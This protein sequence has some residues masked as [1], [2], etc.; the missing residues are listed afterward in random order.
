[1]KSLRS[2]FLL[3]VLLPVILIFGTI[4]AYSIARF[5]QA[6]TASAVA[7]TNNFTELYASEI[8]Y[9]L[10][11]TFAIG[12]I[13]ADMVAG[14][15]ETGE[16]VKSG[17]RN[18]LIN[19]LK[20]L[21]LLDE[22]IYGVW[23]GMEPD[24]YDGMDRFLAGTANHDAT[25][26]FIPYAYRDGQS[27]G[28]AYLEDYNVPGA[29]DYY[30]LAFRSGKPQIVEP[31]DYIIDGLSVKM[32][33]L[34]IPIRLNGKVIGVAG[35]DM[36]TDSLVTIASAL[37]VYDN[38][39]GRLLTN[40]GLVVYHPDQARIGKVENEFSSAEGKQV[41]RDAQKGIT[42]TSWGLSNHLKAESYRT[43]V[44]IKVADIETQWIL[45]SVV[46]KKEM[47]AEVMAILWQITIVMGV[48]FIALAAIILT[49]SGTIVNPIRVLTTFIERIA[50]LDLRPEHKESILPF[51]KKKDE[52]G[53]IA[54][55]L[56][57]M[58]TAL[59]E[60]TTQLQG[61]SSRV[62][63]DS[64]EIAASVGEN[65]AAIQ[66]VTSSMGE[67]GASVSQT[68]DHSLQM[69]ADAKAVEGLASDGNT[70]MRQTLQAMEQIVKLSRES[71]QAL[72]ALSSHVATM[73]GV[74]KIIADVADQTNLLA[75]NAAIEAAR[76][77]E[78]GRG[79]AVVADEV[80]GLAEQT[81]RSVAEINH[82]VAELV[83]NAATS[84]KLMDGTE[85]QI[86][87]GSGLLTQTEVAFGQINE[88]I[89]AVARAIQEF[90]IV[91]GDMSDMGTSVAAAAEEQAASMGEIAR[92]AESL[93]DLGNDLQ[94]IAKRFVI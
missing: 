7:L 72:S 59:F 78:H 22:H 17:S 62:A 26:R 39:Y 49:V 2:R 15:I 20:R 88:R 63:V 60:V 84:T 10:E 73:E 25:G 91:L 74:L 41:L 44:P 21:V 38:G 13:V 93:S 66:E 35:V 3:L 89:N 83:N 82:M 36:T 53:Q 47:L 55:A 45:G 19:T 52:V 79:F 33:T 77:G 31:F 23:L 54:N 94:D 16:A 71:R 64:Q 9:K 46:V 51:L 12:R 1:M 76:A 65:S 70:Q 8:E 56:D 14:Q 75:L 6:Q 30:Q 85:G 4:G 69:G 92:S 40:T 80:R 58:Q 90:T 27:V 86:Q 42:A 67:L 48:A 37:K 87:V 32:I 5:Y 24:A 68:R 11:S 57:G 34:S 18:S 61:I 29:G 50:R 81:R 43:Y 28:L